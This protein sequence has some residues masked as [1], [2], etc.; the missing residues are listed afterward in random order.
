MKKE[1]ISELKEH[2]LPERESDKCDGFEAPCEK[3]GAKWRRQNTN[4]P[5]DS[6]NWKFL[7]DDCQNLSDEYWKDMWDDY[8]AGRL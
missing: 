3:S 8:W 5:T 6:E 7:C 2:N 1:K 4:Y